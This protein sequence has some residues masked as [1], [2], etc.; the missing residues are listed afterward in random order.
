MRRPT[1]QI[2]E[3]RAWKDDIRLHTAPPRPLLA[4]C[5]QAVVPINH[6]VRL[7]VNLR[8]MLGRAVESLLDGARQA[9]LV[10]GC[11]QVILIAVRHQFV[12]GRE[13]VSDAL[14][15]SYS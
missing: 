8:R 7:R 11:G 1:S 15:L 10:R 5:V 3:H 13:V 2:P 14:R 4:P 6:V 12:Q 9:V